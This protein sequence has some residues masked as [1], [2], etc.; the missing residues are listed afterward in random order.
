MDVCFVE[1]EGFTI[2][3]LRVTDDETLRKFQADLATNPE[4]GKLLRNGGGLRKVR[5][6]LPGRGKSAG[7]RVI[8]LWLPEPRCFV[9]VMLY[10]KGKQSDIPAAQLARARE[11]AE[12]LKEIYNQ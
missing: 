3:G 4:S 10:T 8:Y 2:E 11:L 7:A 5:M 12:K 6:K 1:T 9:L